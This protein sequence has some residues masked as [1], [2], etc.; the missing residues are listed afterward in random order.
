VQLDALPAHLRSTKPLKHQGF[1]FLSRFKGLLA[2]SWS[3][4]QP[5]SHDALQRAFGP[6]RQRQARCGCCDENKLRKVVSVARMERSE[7]RAMPFA[8]I[9]S[10]QFRRTRFPSPLWGGSFA[11]GIRARA[12]WGRSVTAERRLSAA[13]AIVGTDSPGCRRPIPVARSA[14]RLVPGWSEAKSG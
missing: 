13:F 1:L 8:W 11:R 4:C 9:R 14:F 5:P 12:G 6:R 2:N 3:I 10:L 7:I